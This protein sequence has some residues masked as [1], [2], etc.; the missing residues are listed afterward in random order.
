MKATEK[1][2]IARFDKDLFEDIVYSGCLNY[3]CLN[4]ISNLTD[5]WHAKTYK[6]FSKYIMV[7]M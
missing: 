4:V 5:V 7:E 3:L 6:L 1:R 2:L